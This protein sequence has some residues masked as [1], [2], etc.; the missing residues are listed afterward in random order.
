MSEQSVS[1]TATATPPQGLDPKVV[2]I[3]LAVVAG[4]IAVI[5][6]T[7][8]VGVA[9]RQLASNLDTTVSTIQWVSTG[10]LL[11]MFVAIPATGW[12]QARIGGKRLWLAALAV[13]LLGSVL[14][15]TA[16]DAPSLI[17]FRV[18]QG[19]GGGVMMPLMSTL[20]V[21]AAQ[22]QPMGRLMA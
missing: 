20:I 3:A 13:F 18:L 15:A 1:G 7:T 8:I 16:W 11:A 22:G 14:C 21:Q 6:D 19:L 12:L 17:G 4:G 5:F 9:L 10:Y 2:K